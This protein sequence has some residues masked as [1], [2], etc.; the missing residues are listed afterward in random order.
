L[1]NAFYITETT[2]TA[3]I[4]GR[5][6]EF[7]QDL[8]GDGKIGIDLANLTKLSTDINGVR[9]AK[10]ANG[11]LYISQ[12]KNNVES[13]VALSGGMMG[14]LE[15]TSNWETRT[16]VAAEAKRSAT[17]D[18]EYYR[19]AVL[20]KS[21]YNTMSAGMPGATSTTTSTDTSTWQKS[22]DILQFDTSGKMVYGSMVDGQWKDVNV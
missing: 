18:I 11:A 3:A 22:W 1:T 14:Q 6:R 15:S 21:S 17:G 4:A 20:R 10:D 2:N 19:V 9:L 13:A 5:E 16:A 7:G 8:N 12:V